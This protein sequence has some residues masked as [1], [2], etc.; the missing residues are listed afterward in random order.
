[1]AQEVKQNSYEVIMEK[2][3]A[4]VDSPERSR[5]A[6]LSLDVREHC[7]CLEIMRAAEVRLMEL[8]CWRNNSVA[9]LGRQA[10]LNSHSR[11]TNWL[12]RLSPC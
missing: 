9:R 2:Q 12:H 1:M 10:E 3:D 6:S 7:F 11:T 8:S 5:N 4:S